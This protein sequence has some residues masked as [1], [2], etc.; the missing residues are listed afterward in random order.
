MRL[1]RDG[2]AG[3]YIEEFVNG[4]VHGHVVRY[5]IVGDVKYEWD[6]LRGEAQ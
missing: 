6:S 4:K 5:D 1:E 2:Y 3:Y